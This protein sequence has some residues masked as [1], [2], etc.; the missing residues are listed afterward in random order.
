MQTGVE[1]V[2]S[3]F[4]IQLFKCSP[5]IARVCEGDEEEVEHLSMII[6]YIPGGCTEDDQSIK[7]RRGE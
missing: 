5:R 1:P 7:T 2:T 6:L 4:I 3:I